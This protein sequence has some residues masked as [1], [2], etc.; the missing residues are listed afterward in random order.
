MTEQG[1]ARKSSR[2]Y[3]RTKYLIDWRHQLATTAQ[4]L[5]VLFGVGL[6]YAIGLLVLP[7]DESVA[8]AGAEEARRVFLQANAI[9]F[10]LGAAIL[11]VLSVILT[12][13]VAGPAFVLERAVQAMRRRDYTQRFTLRKRDY[14]QELAVAFTQLRDE[15]ETKDRDTVAK[16]DDLM[17]C[18]REKD[19]TGALECIRALRERY[20][21]APPAVDA[22][23]NADADLETESSAVDD[24][25]E[26][27]PP[28]REKKSTPAK[29]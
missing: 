11:G 13:R 8:G 27:A 5:G 9:Y 6:L 16:L 28:P 22:H 25:I 17:R 20:T 3:R 21:A 12:H 18:L 23:E 2:R 24:L 14:L 15:L 1:P 29:A 19:G 7:G 10:A 26:N 4:L